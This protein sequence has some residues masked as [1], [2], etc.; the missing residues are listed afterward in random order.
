MNKGFTQVPNLIFDKH[1]SLLTLAELKILLVIIRQTLGWVNKK[2]GNRKT[3]DRISH[4][5][6]IS[7]T[8]LSRK[9][10]SKTIQS[11]YDKGLIIISDYQKNILDS[12][13]KRKGKTYLYY[14]IVETLSGQLNDST[15]AKKAIEPV[16]KRYYNKRNYKKENQIK[17]TAQSISEIIKKYYRKE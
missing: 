13:E 4:A 2:T 3:R 14:A 11:L 8:R 12:S 10:L 16:H 6:F 9:I 1:L 15:Y 5:F 7:K 17:E